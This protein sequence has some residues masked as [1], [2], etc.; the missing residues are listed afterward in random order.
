[1]KILDLTPGGH[2]SRLICNGS[3][4]SSGSFDRIERSVHVGVSAPKGA[5][6]GDVFDGEGGDPSER[7]GVFPH[8]R[9]LDV[10]FP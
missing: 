5:D 2:E 8:S 6:V 1:V 3:V 10:G 9:G 4:L 7:R